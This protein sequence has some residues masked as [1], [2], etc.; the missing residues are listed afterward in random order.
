[1][2]VILYI[3]S[4]HSREINLLFLLFIAEL[5]SNLFFYELD[6]KAIATINKNFFYLTNQRNR[7]KRERERNKKKKEK[8][9]NICVK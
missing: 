2:D 8:K 4:N 7:K 9:I 6:L 5:N 3:L 1:M